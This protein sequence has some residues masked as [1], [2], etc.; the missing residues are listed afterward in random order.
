MTGPCVNDDGADTANGRL[1][2]KDCE[3]RLLQALAT[4]GAD[5]VPLLLVATKRASV[6]CR[7]TGVPRRRRHRHF[8]A[9]ACGSSIARRN[10]YCANW[11][12]GS[13][14]RRP[15]IHAPPSPLWQTP[16]S[17]IRSR[18]CQVG[19]CSPDI[20]TLPIS[21]NRSTRRSTPPSRASRSA[22]AQTAGAWCGATPTNNTANA[23]DA[24]TK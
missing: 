3:R 7:A 1:L 2:C 10:G 18:C 21:P 19:T 17:R 12:C 6:A 16:P 4:T 20:R 15:W 22:H 11:D 5:A 14:T 24:A 9:T 8:C 23:P 13:T